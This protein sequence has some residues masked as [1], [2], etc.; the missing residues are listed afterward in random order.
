M[1]DDKV[2][3]EN[4]HNHNHN[5]NDTDN[6]ITTITPTNRKPQGTTVAMEMSAEASAVVSS[7]SDHDM[8]EEQQQRQDHGGHG[9]A[10]GEQN[11]NDKKNMMNDAALRGQQQKQQQQQQQ[12]GADDADKQNERKEND[13]D[14]DED[15]R[16]RPYLFG[17]PEDPKNADEFYGE[18]LDD[19]DEAWVYKHLRGGTEESVSIR[20]EGS[21]KLEQAKML[22]PRESDAVLSCPLCF[23]I[24]CMDCQQHEQYED[25]FRAMF[26]MN[27]GVDWERKLVYDTKSKALVEKEEPS[28]QLL[29]LSNEASPSTSTT[30]AMSNNDNE[31]DNDKKG[32]AVP[33]DTDDEVYYSVHC[34]NCRTQ[35][36]ALDMSDEVYH[37]FGVLASA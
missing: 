4:N 10:I 24:V 7:D 35:V 23:N 18:D 8:E 31:K 30:A 32:N 21:E 11:P 17:D 33:E 13:D 14:I 5:H 2:E 36:A 29:L 28:K 37:F 22:K 3:T 27:I 25:Q 6:N 15:L 9:K 16:E 26:V 12:K 20:K 19:E 1:R 34:L